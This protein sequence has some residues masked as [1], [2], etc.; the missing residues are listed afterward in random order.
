MT[1]NWVRCRLKPPASRLF[2]QAFFR[3]RPEK[4][5]KLRVT[6][7][8]GIH[9]WP[10]NSPHK[11]SVTR[12]MFPLGDVIMLLNKYIPLNLHPIRSLIYF[13]LVYGRPVLSIY[14]CFDWL[15]HWSWNKM[16]AISQPT[17][18]SAFS[19]MEM[20]EFLLKFHCILLLGAQLTI[21]NHWFR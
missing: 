16:T 12:K 8:C 13:V 20:H 19:W 21:S 4:T 6:G 10:V 2:T 18:W 5:S 3:R 1:S 17:F 11:G 14:F 9:R 7:P 15:T